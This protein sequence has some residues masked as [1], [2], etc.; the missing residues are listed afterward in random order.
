[1]ARRTRKPRPEAIRAAVTS[2]HGGLA[3][4]TD[5]QIR[6]VWDALDESTRAAY[7]AGPDAPD[8]ALNPPAEETRNHADR[9]RSEPDL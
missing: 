1:M 7:L 9:D 6:R 8:A 2:R 4:A 3:D 5:A